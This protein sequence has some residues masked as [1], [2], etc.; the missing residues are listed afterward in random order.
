MDKFG[1]SY[2]L[3]SSFAF[4]LIFPQSSLQFL[5]SLTHLEQSYVYTQ[6]FGDLSISLFTRV[7]LL[8]QSIDCTET[9]NPLNPIT[10]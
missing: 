6:L 8:P 1:P 2:I 4:K 3:G 5:F 9:F 7:H 10:F